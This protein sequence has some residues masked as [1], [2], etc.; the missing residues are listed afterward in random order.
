MYIS[1]HTKTPYEPLVIH[2]KVD[3]LY[4]NYFTVYE[5][6][7]YIYDER[8]GHFDANGLA[9]GAAGLNKYSTNVSIVAL[10]EYNKPVIQWVFTKAFPSELSGLNLNFQNSDEIELSA[11][12]LF[13]QMLVRGFRGNLS[14]DANV[15]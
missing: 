15:S 9:K 6:L 14:L 1:S 5:W 2:M 11:T 3:N 7:N 8:E 4:N 10:D 13:S 12:F